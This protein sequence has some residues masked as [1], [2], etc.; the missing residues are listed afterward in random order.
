MTRV[1]IALLLLASQVACGGPTLVDPLPDE[2][3]E[4]VRAGPGL[5]SGDLSGPLQIHVKFLNDED[6]GII[7]SVDPETRI[8]DLRSRVERSASPDV[9]AVGAWVLVEY[10]FVNQSCPGQSDAEEID[11]LR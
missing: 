9:L 10:R 6:C 4:I 5:W 3:G 8:T 1:P 11:R 2:A 7:F